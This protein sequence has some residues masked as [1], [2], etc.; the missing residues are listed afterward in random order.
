MRFNDFIGYVEYLQNYLE[1]LSLLNEGLFVSVV[2]DPAYVGPHI[3]LTLIL[4]LYAGSIIRMRTR[5][6]KLWV[7]Q[8]VEAKHTCS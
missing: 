5:A 8:K 4:T 1:L 2:F 6:R 3:D 7:F